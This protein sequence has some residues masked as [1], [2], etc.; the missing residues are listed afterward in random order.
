[1]MLC[2]YMLPIVFSF[3]FLSPFLLLF[4]LL[5]FLF[6]GFE[7]ESLYTV[8]THSVDQADLELT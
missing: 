1:M 6:L 2:R 3:F 8:L 5:Y 4:L 7:T